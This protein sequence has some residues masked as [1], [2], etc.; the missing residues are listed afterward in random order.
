MVT[1]LYAGLNVAESPK[2]LNQ[3][4]LVLRCRPIFGGDDVIFYGQNLNSKQYRCGTNINNIYN[5]D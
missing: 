4:I 3:F 2:Y 5:S 1:F